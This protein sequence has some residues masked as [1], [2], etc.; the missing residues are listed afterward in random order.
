MAQGCVLEL[1]RSYSSCTRRILHALPKLEF[2]LPQGTLTLFPDD[3]IDFGLHDTCV[4][5]IQ[6]IGTI[7]ALELSP[8]SIP[9]T[10]VRISHGG[11]VWHIC[12]SAAI[13]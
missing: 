10:N 11:N 4:I 8:L 13:L 9:G 2:Q 1:P 3:Y 6:T 7:P 5:K 12:E